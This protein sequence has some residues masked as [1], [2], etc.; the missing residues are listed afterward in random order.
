MLKIEKIDIKEDYAITLK[1]DGKRNLLFIIN[2][3]C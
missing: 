1:F 2:N 3:N